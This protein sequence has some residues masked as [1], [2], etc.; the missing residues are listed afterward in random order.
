MIAVFSLLEYELRQL[1]ELYGLDTS[2]ARSSLIQLLAFARSKKVLSAE[3]FKQIQQ[4]ATVRNKLA[5]TRDN[6]SAAVAR[7]IVRDT[8][9]VISKVREA[10]LTLRS[11]K[12]P[13]AA[14]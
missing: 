5:H 9:R 2:L 8:M 10:N 4:H 6:V 3:E 12:D 1:F 13:T 7:T 14:A 11:T